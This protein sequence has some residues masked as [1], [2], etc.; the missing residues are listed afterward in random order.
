MAGVHMVM[1]NGTGGASE[2][3][4]Y[5]IIYFQ[6]CMREIIKAIAQ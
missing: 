2:L 6:E 4:K 3:Y 5:Y 1:H